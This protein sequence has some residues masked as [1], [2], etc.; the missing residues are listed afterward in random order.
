MCKR[1]LLPLSQHS[2]QNT[3]SK[4]SYLLPRNYM[5]NLP[6]AHPT[7]RMNFHW[8]WPFWSGSVLIISHRGKYD[9]RLKD[10]VL[11]FLETF[12]NVSEKTNTLQTRQNRNPELQISRQFRFFLQRNM[13]PFPSKQ[14]QDGVWLCAKA[15]QGADQQHRGIEGSQKRGTGERSFLA[16]V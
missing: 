4:R 7:R 1:A 11:S 9:W 10:K 5:F 14:N 12:P 8:L 2:D 15:G 13:R 3:Q 16:N 6:N